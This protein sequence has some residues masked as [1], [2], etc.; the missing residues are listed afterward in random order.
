M[1]TPKYYVYTL[2]YPSG[3]VFYV[4]KGTRDRLHQHE[5]EAKKGCKCKKC[6]VIRAIL[7]SGYCISKSIVFTT[8]DETE[9]YQEEDRLMKSL[10]GLLTNKIYRIKEIKPRNK[11]NP[12]RVILSAFTYPLTTCNKPSSVCW[13][14]SGVN[15]MVNFLSWCVIA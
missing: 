7:K 15:N 14:V 5:K 13:T 11:T 12:Q 10:K 4:G 8:D 1:S 2:S 6:K 9:A 3:I